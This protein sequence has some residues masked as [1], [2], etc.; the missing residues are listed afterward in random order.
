MRVKYNE[1]AFVLFVGLGLLAVALHLPR[2]DD[3]RALPWLVT[4]WCTSLA[5]H[6]LLLTKWTRI[7]RAFAAWTFV[8]PLATLASGSAQI[9]MSALC[10][11]SFL[12]GAASLLGV[13]MYFPEIIVTELDVERLSRLLD[14][15]PP[16]QRT[17]ASGLETELA[18][19]RVVPSKAV[20]PDVVTMNSR[21]LFEDDSGKRGEVVLGYPHHAS[22]STISVL[23]PVGT[24]LLG[25]RRGQSIDWRMPTGRC[26]RIRV[27]D[28]LYQPEAAGDFHL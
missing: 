17:A 23:A 2:T 18:R 15:L 12:V 1:L 6:A 13:P 25:L 4:L 5:C 24:A 14:V 10:L 9:A 16:A 20:P 8:L 11:I 22:E 26:K 27:L 19:A 28:V 7:A 3:A 21:L